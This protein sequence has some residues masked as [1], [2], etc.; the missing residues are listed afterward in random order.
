MKTIANIFLVFTLG[1]ALL[2]S[3]GIILAG[4]KARD[5]SPNPRESYPSSLTSEG[6]TIAVEPFFTDALA[7]RVLD[8]EDIVTRGIMPLAIIIFNDNDFP[9]E[10][11]ALSIEL[12]REDDHIR[13]LMP[14]EA[15]NRL[16]RKD[17]YQIGQST[18]KIVNKKALEDFDNKF[19]MDKVIAPHSRSGGF[20][21][22][23]IYNPK[24]LA[25][26]LSSAAV[27]IPNVVRHDDGSRLIFF[28]ISLNAAVQIGARRK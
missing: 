2:W 15:L 18:P 27:Y 13:T 17:K 24:D 16:F 3:T 8:K 1:I 20:L 26:Y 7:A 12:I 6:V 5:W 9:I 22:M 19:L 21:Y 28:E 4:Y 10:V 14:M 25:S 11:D 23:K